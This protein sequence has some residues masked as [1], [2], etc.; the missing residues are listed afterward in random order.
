MGVAMLV[1]QYGLIRQ[2]AWT[3]IGDGFR[4]GA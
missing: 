1:M 4:Q 3:I 2:D